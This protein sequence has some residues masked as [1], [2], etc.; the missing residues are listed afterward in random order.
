MIKI[1]HV[2]EVAILENFPQE[3]IKV[4][5]ETVKILDEAY[6]V[7]RDVDHGNGGYVLVIEAEEELEQLKEIYLDVKTVIPEYTDIIHVC[8]G[9][10]YTCSLILLSSDFALLLVVIL[11]MTP[12][13]WL[14]EP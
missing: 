13:K 1:A 4:I 7:N 12:E 5:R 6:S 11:R 8:D 10:D 3:V 2:H 14:L 9:E